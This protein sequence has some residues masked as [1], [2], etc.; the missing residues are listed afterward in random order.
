LRTEPSPAPEAFRQSARHT[1]FVE[2]HE[3]SI[4]VLAL[5]HLLPVQL[6]IKGL[7]PSL[8]IRAAAEALRPHHSD[9]YFLI[10]RDH[11]DQ[12]AVDETW[13]RF[14]SAANPDARNLLM[15]RRRELESYF[16]IPQYLEKS[17]YLNCSAEAL[18]SAILA[19]F[20]RRVFFDAANRVIVQL[21]E[22]L[23]RKWIEVFPSPEPLNTRERA[24][25]ALLARPEFDEFTRRSSGVLAPD[26]IAESFEEALDL[27]TGGF[28]TLQF[29]VGQWLELMEAKKI[30]NIIADRFRVVT[31]AG[32]ILDGRDRL[33]RIVEQ[34]L[35][36]ELGEQ[37]DDFQQLHRLLS[38]R[39]K[40]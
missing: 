19:E 6:T 14:P 10:D 22:A 36:L 11:H 23:R 30:L 1:L 4:D 31:S 7:G 27:L 17:A 40:T 3:G 39:L 28:A 33:R 20:Q 16:L 32:E 38:E 5:R 8:N 2:G 15:W 35:K 37:P 34:L 18:R 24:R 25:A 26:T 21:R 9:Y 12:A 13:N 29:G